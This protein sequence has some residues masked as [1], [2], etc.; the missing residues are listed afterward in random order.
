MTVQTAV[1]T[2]VENRRFV[3]R[4]RPSARIESSTFELRTE[5]VPSIGDGQ[6]LVRVDWM[7]L[8]PSN[9]AWIQSTPTYLPP[10]AIGDV[11]RG[12]G[13]G[14][15]VA[16][17]NR[18]YP[19]GQ[20]VQGLT[21]WQEYAVVSDAEPLQPV[22]ISAGVSPSAYLGVLGKTGLVAW[23]GIR[24]IGRPRPGETVLVSAASGAVGSV[25]GQLAKVSGARVVGIAGGPSKCAMLTEELAF[26]AAVDY[27]ADDWA[28]QLVAATPDGIDV[29][30][31]NVGGEIMDAVFARLNI[32]ARV[33]LCG[34][35]SGYNAPEPPTG[36]R[37]FSQ[38][39]TKRVTLQG[40]TLGDHYA[41]GPEAGKEIS[42]LIAQ[43]RL[44]PLE[45]VVDGFD[46]LPTAINMLFDGTNTGKLVVKITD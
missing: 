10:V 36:P 28:D 26:D 7:S 24:Q 27:K 45:T 17:N 42:G 33:V 3:L 20:T 12:W 15:V 23:V 37:S 9:R 25:A 46:Q 2:A 38:L 39:L 44:K 13:L 41:D 34:L 40:F 21:G 43:G 8:D 1:E 29:D 5:S 35:I 31:E 11:M 18:L 22:E 6:A 32:H 19:V 14:T 30:F 16:S 4:E